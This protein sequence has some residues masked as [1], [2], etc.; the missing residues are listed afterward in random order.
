[1]SEEIEIRFFI[2]RS[3]GK[4]HVVN[5]LRNI[6]E[7]VEIHDDHFNQATADTDWLP[8]V[9]LKGWVILTADK[10]IA[11]RRLE[12]MAVQESGARMFVLVSGNLSGI[13]MAEIFVQAVPAM[14]R[15]IANTPAPFMAKVHKNAS[16]KAWK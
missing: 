9:A 11:H 2:D 1:M 6:G 5:A 4:T 16:V 8:I 15:F 14:K 7:L 3:L 12:L 13:E 10:K